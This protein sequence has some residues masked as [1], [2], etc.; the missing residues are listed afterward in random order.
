M[1]IYHWMNLIMTLIK[2]K[3]IVVSVISDILFAVLCI[4]FKILKIE[5][6]YHFQTK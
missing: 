2:L 3:D 1:R 5:V 6:P 4:L